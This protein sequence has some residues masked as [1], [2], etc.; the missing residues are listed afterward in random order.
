MLLQRN[1]FGINTHFSRN[2][3]MRDVLL[4]IKIGGVM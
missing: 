3:L 2:I 4:E 1:I